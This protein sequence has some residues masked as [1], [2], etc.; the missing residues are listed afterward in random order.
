MPNPLPKPKLSIIIPVYNEEKTLVEIIK[1]IMIQPWDKELIA[2]D[3]GSTDRSLAILHELS[4]K[5]DHLYVYSQKVNKGKGAAL[6]IGFEKATGDII[7]IQDADLEYDPADYGLLLIPLLDGRADVVYG[8]RFLGGPHRV[9][10]HH[11]YIANKFLTNLSNLCT[12]LNL[13][14]METCYKAFRK[15]V[16]SLVHLREDRFGFEPEFTAQIAYH[17]LAIYEVPIS[18]SGRTYEEGKK[19]GWKDG[20][21][22]LKVILAAQW[23]LRRSK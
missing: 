6:R 22:A 1:R 10:N 4:Q 7:I 15:E 13:S 2:I 11:H 9:L 5:H 17:N 3:D 12:N 20:M 16:L 23:H 14:D 19:I 18:Y 8:S 21:Q